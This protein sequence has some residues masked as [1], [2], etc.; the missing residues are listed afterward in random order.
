MLNLLTMSVVYSS[1]GK[2][3]LTTPGSGGGITTNTNEPNTTRS[4]SFS[5]RVHSD[6]SG[7]GSKTANSATTPSGSFPS[8]GASAFG[9]GSGAFASFGSTRTPKTPSGALDF[10]TGQ[11]G[12]KPSGTGD[13]KAGKEK[14]AAKAPS[15]AAIAES[16]PLEAPKAH[17]LLDKWVFWWR[18]PISKSQGGFTEYEKTL[19]P[20]CH[21]STVQE[22]GWVYRHLKRP[23]QLPTMSEY[24][25]FKY[26]IRPIW[27]D[28]EN[29]KGGKWVVRLR[30]GVA[31][32]YWED[33]IFALIGGQFGDAGE[34]VCGVVVSM[35]NGEDVV[36]IW[37]RKD[38]GRV[39]KIR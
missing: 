34:E 23:S 12:A 32:H 8:P 1:T 14:V 10:A 26:G 24:H 13:S 9:L 11:V 16:K 21:C 7:L 37:T 31:D 17:P 20:M 5:K 15:M 22:F 25:F 18:P 27:E 19:H 39:V 2:L 38:G 36:S 4:A 35:K 33:L 3:S 28:D 6:G 29:R 30:K